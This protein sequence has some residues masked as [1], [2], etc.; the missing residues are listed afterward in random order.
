MKKAM[1]YEKRGENTAC[2][3]CAHGCVIKLDRTGLCGVRKNIGGE[4]YT[5]N[6]GKLSA[7]N[8]DPVE[9]KPLKHF[10]PGTKTLSI[11]SYGCNFSCLYCQNWNIAHE[12]PSYLVEKTPEE[13]VDMTIEEGYPSIS[14]TYNEPTVFYEFMLD[15]AKLAKE[16]GLMNIM[17]TNGFIQR[18]PIELLLQYIDAM[19]IDL[20]TFRA[21]TYKSICGGRLEPV[22]ETIKIAA[23]KCHVEVTTLIVTGMNDNEQELTELFEWLASVDKGIPLHITRY[24]PA[25][26]YNEP[27]TD[28]EFMRKMHEKAKRYL[29][30]VYLGNIW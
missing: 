4:L 9:K 30:N 29:D 16:K 28:V 20:K 27:P 14:Y 7:I 8:I 10:M 13:I 19:N 23:K 12:T 1:F 26:K 17:V 25:Y 5:L 2:K 18:E 11:G 3:L 21:E 6:Y 15:T 22:K 24:F